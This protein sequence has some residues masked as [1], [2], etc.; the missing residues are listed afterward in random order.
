MRTA[1]AGVGREYGEGI[2]VRDRT[3]A[4]RCGRGIGYALV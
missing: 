2:V 4:G 3:G 1:Y